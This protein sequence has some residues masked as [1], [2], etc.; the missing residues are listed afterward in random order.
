MVVK[1]TTPTTW[2]QV[3]QMLATSQICKPRPLTLLKWQDFITVH[4]N[5]VYPGALTES[6]DL[7]SYFQ[8][9]LRSQLMFGTALSC[10]I[11]YILITYCKRLS[12]SVPK[13]G[14]TLTLK[15]R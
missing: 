2:G 8:Q 9:L 14:I 12:Q 13:V 5:G 1:I 3:L 7:S 10:A 6:H 11:G 4:I 15:G